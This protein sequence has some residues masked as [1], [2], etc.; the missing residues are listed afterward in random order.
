MR[1]G[2]L[3]RDLLGCAVSELREEGIA[4][5]LLVHDGGVAEAQMHRGCYSQSVQSPIDGLD[6]DALGGVRIGAQP[7]II[8]LD[9]IGRQPP[10][11]VG[12]PD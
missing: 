4:G 5:R 3:N 8:E 2:G 12:P 1:L 9:D 10:V 6:G 11:A 7:G